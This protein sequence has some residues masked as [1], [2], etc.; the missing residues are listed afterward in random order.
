[1]KEQKTAPRRLLILV[2][3]LGMGGAEHMIYELVRALDR[4]RYVPEV[5]CYGPRFGNTLE[6]KVEAVCPVRYLG[7]TGKITLG[8]M[9]Q[10]LAAVRASR[11]DVIHAHQGGVTFAVPWCLLHR[12]P[13]CITV[14]SRPQQAFSSLNNRMLRAAKH[15][16]RL[17]MVAVSQEN[18]ALVQAYYRLNDQRSRCI[19]N[20]V[21]LDRFYKTPHERFTFINVARQDEN[22]N[23]IALV[24]AVEAL[25]RDGYDVALRLVGDGPCHAMLQSEVAARGLTEHVV[26]PGNVPDPETQYAVSDVYVQVSHREAMPLSVLEAMA[27]GLPIIATDVGGL[28]DVV[29]QNGVLI[30]DGDDDA[31]LSA[32]KRLADASPA[33]YDRMA[34]QSRQIVNEYSSVR[35]AE[36][37]EQAYDTLCGNR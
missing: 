35:M 3:G 33:E 28:K 4:E 10:V 27:S 26:L 29:R 20:G 2:N 18:L 24:R 9:K 11:P 30:P 13:L 37:Y 32:M 22:K 21:S 19:N 31:L 36:Q 8:A 23:Q 12:T 15:L 1:M 7:I 16:V 34:Q 5:L 14:H 17:T 25:R 6:D